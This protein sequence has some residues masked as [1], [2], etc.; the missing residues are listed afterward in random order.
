MDQSTPSP[1][2]A[3]Q[4][5]L[6]AEADPRADGLRILMASSEAH[7]L[8]KTGGLADVA[9]SLPA[10]LAE[11]GHDARLIIPAYP[12]AVKQ[13]REPK[14]LCEI[15]LPG[16]HQQV[17]ILGGRMPDSLL[18]VYLIDAPDHFCREGS[19]YTDLTGRDWG[20]NAERFMLFNRVL[21]R[22]GMGLPALGWRPQIL[23]CNDWQTGLAPAL[24]Q[25]TPERPAT[26][27][28]VHNL[29]YQG[30]FD[31]A[32]FDRLGLAPGLWAVNGLEFHQRMSFI[33]GGLVFSDLVNT[34]SPTYA[35]EVRTPR[36]GCGLDGL[37]RQLGGRFQGILNGIDYGIWNPVTDPLIH[38]NYGVEDVNLKVENKLSLQR[39][40]GLPRNER[41]LLFGYIGRLVEQ[42]GVDMILDILPRL[43]ERHDVQVVLQT[44]GDLRMERVLDGLAAANPDQVAVHASYDEARAHR[45]EAGCDAFLMPSRFEPCGLNQ[46]YSL[47]YGTVPIVRRTGGLA[48]TVVHASPEHLADGTAT[49]FLF[50]E[51]T[52]DALW[53]A[54]EQALALY[55]EHPEQWR[56]MAVRGMGLDFSWERSAGEYERLYEEALTE[57]RNAV[58]AA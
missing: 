6:Q 54:A 52:A 20:D 8:I 55:R 25:D 12:R 35:D 49:G 5:K 42:K 2:L 16:S 46:M 37:L 27:F 21:A 13:V 22:I 47:R 33:K 41:A 57:R 19:P 11:L 15:R 34:V 18:Q 10:A 17:R 45:I 23:H 39:E 3:P 14:P 28:T 53:R 58:P 26:I 31:R 24:L 50:D 1:R 40:L 38:Q 51:P 43:L 36:Y 4:N 32:T 56:A 7:P 44:T 30:L 9:A 29:A 48:D